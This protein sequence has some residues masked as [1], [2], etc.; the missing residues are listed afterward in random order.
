MP[1][2]FHLPFGMEVPVRSIY[3]LAW[4][5]PIGMEVP[6]GS[7]YPLGS[8]YP[9]GSIYLSGWK[10]L[11]GIICPFGWKETVGFIYLSGSVY[12]SGWKFPLDPFTLWVGKCLSSY[13]VPTMDYT[14]S[15]TVCVFP[16]YASLSGKNLHTM[17]KDP[18]TY[19]YPPSMG[20]RALRSRNI[21]SIYFI[22]KKI[23]CSWDLVQPYTT[24]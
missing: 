12:L 23:L 8:I 21:N 2:E 9:S 16:T 1:F 3:P 13:L 17:P 19:L 14:K 20:S 5:V 7:I 6:V 18:S 24:I 22:Q 10:V 11:V 4:K 15:Q